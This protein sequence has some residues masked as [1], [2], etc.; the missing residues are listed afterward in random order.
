MPIFIYKAVSANGE[1]LEGEIDAPSK[2]E[3]IDQLQHAGHIPLSAVEK[4]SNGHSLFTF[5]N[6]LKPRQINIKDLM[7][8]TRE[9]STLMQ[10]GLPLDQSLKILEDLNSKP[11]LKKMVVDINNRIKSGDSISVAM[12]AQGQVFDKMYL[13][14]I[15]AGEAGGALQIVLDR[16]ADY[17]ERTAEFRANV[18]SALFYPAILLLVSM[19]SIF[20]LLSF[21]VPQFVPLFEDV[22]QALPLLTQI[23]FDCAGIIQNYWWMMF[24]FLVL[25][26]WLGDKQLQNPETRLLWD[27]KCLA[28]PIYGDLITK[29]DV[30]RFARTLGTL[31]SNGVPLLTSIEIVKE[32]INNKMLANTIGKAA[33]GLEQG[34]SLTQP[35]TESEYFP[36]LAVQLIRVGEETGQLESM[37]LKTAEI[38]ENESRITIKRLLTLLEPILILGLGAIIAIIIIS[39]LMAMLGLNELVI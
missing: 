3:V 30:A 16:L 6:P 11:S 26:I 19:L 28:I 24:A 33:T 7:L 23:V 37:L 27:T 18:I 17:M 31:L 8:F 20:I 12:E 4:S 25:L 32:V 10:A 34:R 29:L 35:L 9:L 1:T 14:T 39:I 22:G 36:P 38:Y 5:K 2:S 15:R 21:V 13:N